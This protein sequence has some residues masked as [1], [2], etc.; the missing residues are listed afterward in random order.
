MKDL[1]NF[2]CQLHANAGKE[3][4]YVSP[5]YKYYGRVSIGGDILG[6]L[7]NSKSARS[8]S[9]IAAYWPTYGS[10][11]NNFDHSQR[12]IGKVQYYIQHTVTLKEMSSRT[13]NI[14]HFTLAYVHWM[15]YHHDNRR[16]GTSATVCAN[17]VKEVYMCSFIPVLRIFAKCA[18]CCTDLTDE[19]V[20]VAC[21]I[22]LKLSI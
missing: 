10:D 11:L 13:S 4:E 2:Y 5:F 9:V 14:V 20:F 21:P 3:I 22:P 16:Y 18:T 1:C 12:S 8:S 15:D 7:L 17:S 19:N 6:S